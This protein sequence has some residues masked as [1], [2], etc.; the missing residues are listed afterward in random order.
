M[1]LVALALLLQE[2]CAG[3]HDLYAIKW[4]SKKG[5]KGYPSLPTWVR[6]WHEA[7]LL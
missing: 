4:V 1:L 7:Q 2:I 5:R 6:Q 3:R